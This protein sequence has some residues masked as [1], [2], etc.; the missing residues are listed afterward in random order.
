[1]K[2]SAKI[3]IIL[4]VLSFVV[5]IGSAL[6]MIINLD[7]SLLISGLIFSNLLLLLGVIGLVT[8]LSGN[9]KR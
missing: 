3:S 4:I 8:N 6:P 7:D 9:K 5:A 2:L 1:M